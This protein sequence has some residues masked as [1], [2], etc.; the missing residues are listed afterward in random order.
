LHA[1]ASCQIKVGD[2]QTALILNDRQFMILLMDQLVEKAV[3]LAAN[4][5]RAA[6]NA[7]SLDVVAAFG[8]IRLLQVLEFL[9]AL[10]ELLYS[11]LQLDI[12]AKSFDRSMPSPSD[13]SLGMSEL[14]AGQSPEAHRSQ[15]HP[16]LR[17][18]V[19]ECSVAESPHRGGDCPT[20]GVQVR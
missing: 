18:A 3:L 15:C 16:G 5:R 13:P 9:C 7:I 6:R 11:F 2:V 10:C 14:S 8:L 20:I 19:P 12:A 4:R 17:A 1:D